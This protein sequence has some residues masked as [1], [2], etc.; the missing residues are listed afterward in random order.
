MLPTSLRCGRHAHVRLAVLSPILLLLYLLLNT[1]KQRGHA[2]ACLAVRV[3]DALEGAKEQGGMI[4]GG[5]HVD[6]FGKGDQI[7][8]VN[9]GLTVYVKM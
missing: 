1:V 2:L 6:E 8:V 4:L 3:K 5:L 7:L 9:V